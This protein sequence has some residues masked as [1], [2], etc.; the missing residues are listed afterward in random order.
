MDLSK[1]VC[2]HFKAER[3]FLRYSIIGDFGEVQISRVKQ[4]L[5]AVFPR[6]MM[7][8]CSNKIKTENDGRLEQP[9]PARSP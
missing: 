6:Y 7:N 3:D 5:L 9:V 8:I 1:F 4:N 2:R